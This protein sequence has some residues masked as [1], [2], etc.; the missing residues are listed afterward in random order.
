MEP[1]DP[2]DL[3]ATFVNV[4]KGAASRIPLPDLAAVRWDQL[5]YLGWR[6]QRNPAAAFIVAPYDGAPRGIALRLAPRGG[7]S[8]RQSMCSLCHTVHSSSGVALMVAA[9]AGRSGR[10][11]N[12]VGTYLCTDLSC[13]AYARELKKPDRVQPHETVSVEAK[14]ARLQLNMEAFVRRVLTP[15]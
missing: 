11:G 9:R 8:K 4:T 13:P 2:G 10:D 7:P 6:D 1:I 3:R 14:V 12:T 15:L 5:D